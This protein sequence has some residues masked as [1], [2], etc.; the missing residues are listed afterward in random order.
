VVREGRGFAEDLEIGRT[1]ILG[2]RG[3]GSEA[4]PGHLQRGSD[5][6]LTG[7]NKLKEEA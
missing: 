1:A 7:G 2:K 6:L 4:G 3:V 5:F